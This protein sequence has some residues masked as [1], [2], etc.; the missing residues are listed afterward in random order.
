LQKAVPKKKNPRRMKR[1][2][3]TMKSLKRSPLIQSSSASLAWRL[4]ASAA[5]L[6]GGLRDA[7]MW[8]FMRG[9]LTLGYGSL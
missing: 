1:K 3:M 4:L 8:G 7:C 2:K 9:M 6:P 5:V